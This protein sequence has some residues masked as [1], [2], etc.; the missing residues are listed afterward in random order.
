MTSVEDILRN[1]DFEHEINGS[2]LSYFYNLIE[3]ELNPVSVFNLNLGVIEDPE[4]FTTW[5]SDLY[6]RELMWSTDR[7]RF[8]LELYEF[9]GFPLTARLLRGSLDEM[10]TRNY[11]DMGLMGYGSDEFNDR[12]KRDVLRYIVSELLQVL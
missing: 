4:V 2:Y 8:V 9:E 12:K 11:T 5:L 10:D 3:D 7:Y 1:T 6:Y